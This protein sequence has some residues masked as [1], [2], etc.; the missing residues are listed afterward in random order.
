MANLEQVEEDPK[1]VK[2]S[3]EV[4]ALSLPN[5]NG[6]ST[7]TATYTITPPCLIPS[8]ADACKMVSAPYSCLVMHTH[9]RHLALSPMYLKKKRTGIQDE[10]NTELLRYSESLKGVPLAYDNIRILGPQGNIH[11]DSGYIHLDVEASFVVF[12]P[13]RGKQILGVVNKLALN[14]V[15]CLVHGCFNASIPKPSL[16]PV[17]TWRENGP[18]IGAELEFLVS[19]LDADTAGVMLIRGMLDRTRVQ[20]LMAMGEDS[21]YDF[22]I[23]DQEDP[24]VDRALEPTVGPTVEPTVG[25]TVEPT[26]EPT[27]EPTVEPT[28]EPTVDSV[29]GTLTPKK[30]KKNKHRDE[31][32]AAVPPLSPPEGALTQELDGAAEDTSINTHS[33]ERE[34]KKKKKKR[35]D[36]HGEEESVVP[37]SIFPEVVVKQEPNETEGADLGVEQKKKKKKKKKEKEVKEEEVKEEEVSVPIE[38]PVRDS[39]SYLSD[40]PNRKRK[41]VPFDDITSCFERDP[42]TPKSKKKKKNEAR[43]V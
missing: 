20:E 1:P 43:N 17:E 5:P 27:V 13:Q 4:S 19:Q 7:L 11:D 12:K 41:P 21:G 24:A 29:D 32:E 16:V 31:E 2:T 6:L 34:K 39:S 26:I 9:R 38:V 23:E 37:C 14:H 40:K 25:P 18:E 30:K 35:K 8:F 33:G 15:G 10:L 3:T 36:K 22:P 28:I 42:E